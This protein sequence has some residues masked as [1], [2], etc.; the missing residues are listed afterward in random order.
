[1]V[2]V[3]VLGGQNSKDFMSLLLVVLTQIKITKERKHIPGRSLS[4]QREV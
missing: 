2:K 3:R 4:K 1:M